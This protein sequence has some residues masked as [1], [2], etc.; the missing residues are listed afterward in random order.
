ME[1]ITACNVDKEQRLFVGCLLILWRDE[2]MITCF[3]LNS[4]SSTSRTPF[5][6]KRFTTLFFCFL[7]LSHSIQ[8][9]AESIGF[10]LHDNADQSTFQET[11]VSVVDDKTLQPIPDALVT[12][13]EHTAE[14][15]NFDG[16]LQLSDWNGSSRFAIAGKT[17]KTVTAVKQGYAGA[18]LIGARSS[19]VTIF[20]K[21]LERESQI[22]VASGNVSGWQH[23]NFLLGKPVYMGAVFRN[24]NAFDLLQFQVGTLISPLK[25]EIDVFGKRQIPSN[26]VMPDQTIPIFLGSVRVNKPH[27]RFPMST[28]HTTRLAVLQAQ[29]DSS[30]LVSIGQSGKADASTLN[31]V[32]FDRI[33]LSD[34]VS[35]AG[36]FKQDL[37]AEYALQAAHRVTV[38]P[39]PFPSDVVVIAVTDLQGDWQAL[40]PTDIKAPI[41]EKELL[42]QRPITQ[43]PISLR[44][45]PAMP[46]FPAK[47]QALIT[48]AST[49]DLKRISGII[50]ATAGSQVNPG[51]YLDS[52]PIADSKTLPDQVQFRAPTSGIGETVFR[53]QESNSKHTLP[54]WFV[55]TLP[56]AGQVT[57]NT[58]DL[59][60]QK[61]VTQYSLLQL[62]FDPAFNEHEVDGQTIITRLKRFASETAHIR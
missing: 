2:K 28:G 8:A 22:S 5:V 30:E 49:K 41:T 1:I 21:P 47:N 43:G 57:I 10:S 45:L 53:A 9:K 56:E 50:T 46:A 24:L 42:E 37:H 20:L 62:E 54:V 52:Q 3:T 16:E 44:S 11:A 58:H 13:R 40:I 61:K 23:S 18:T 25:D 36:D 48:V 19:H 32:Q 15:E 31:K 27:Y 12:V 34:I 51:A 35:A 17:P 4:T 38:N 59:P 60:F 6:S 39:P 7:S 29:I 33:G 14:I 55:Y 26:L